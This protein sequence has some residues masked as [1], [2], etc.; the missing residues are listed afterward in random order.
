[1]LTLRAC[2][3]E[4]GDE[5][6]SRMRSARNESLGPLDERGPNKPEIVD[7]IPIGGTMLERTGLAETGDIIYVKGGR[8]VNIGL[9][10]QKPNNVTAP[11]AGGKMQGE[12][13]SEHQKIRKSLLQVSLSSYLNK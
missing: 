12:E 2:R 8:S 5:H 9:S 3:S 4:I 10:L 7:G 11:S 1:M 6:L 13:L